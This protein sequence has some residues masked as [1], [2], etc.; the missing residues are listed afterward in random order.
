MSRQR[1]IFCRYRQYFNQI[2]SGYNPPVYSSCLGTEIHPNLDNFSSVGSKC[3]GITFRVY[4]SHCFL[5]C[6]V[7]F[8]FHHIDIVG[9]FKHEV[10]SSARSMIFHFSM[11]SHKLEHYIKNILIVHFT[12]AWS[13]FV[14]YIIEE[15]LKAVQERIHITFARRL[16]NAESRM[17]ILLR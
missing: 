13:K 5:G 12:V 9:G 10:H 4:L 8:E 2:K 6:S 17:E 7:K 15:C 16:R 11:E 1:Y 14:W 3:G